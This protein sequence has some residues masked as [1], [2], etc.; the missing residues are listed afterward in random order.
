[1]RGLGRWKYALIILL[2]LHLVPIW[3]FKFLPTQD[4]LNHVYNAYILKEYNNP[5]YTK[6]REVYRLNIKPLPN[7]NAHAFLFVMLHIVPPLIAEKFYVSFCVLLAPFAFFYF[8]KQVDIRLTLFALLGFLYSYNYFINLGFYG[9]ALGFSVYFFALGYWWRYRNE[10][11]FTRAAVFNLLI[12]ATYFSHLFSYSMLLLSISLLALTSAVLPGDRPRLI[13]E[14]VKSFA[15]T[16]AALLPAYSV[17]LYILMSNPEDKKAQIRSFKRLWDFFLSVHSLVSFNDRAVP[18]VWCLLGLMGL[19]FLWKVVK[20]KIIERD[21]IGQRDGF[22]ILFCISAL[23]YFKLPWAYGSPG[24][25]NA[26]MNLFLF[27]ILLAWFSFTYPKWLQ[28]ALAAVLICLALAHLGM[29]T[30]DYYLL[31]K[32]MR[33]FTSGAHLIAPNSSISIIRSTSTDTEYHGPLKHATP[34]YHATCYYGLNNGGVYVG[35][36]EPKYVYFPLRYRA[37]YWKFEYKGIIDYMLVWRKNEQ[38]EEVLQLKNE[39]ELI[40]KTKNLMLFRFKGTANGR[41]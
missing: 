33:E 39:Y 27:P 8:L 31:D 7:L 36:Y 25:I 23:L 35:N 24:W 41:E 5:E 26:R 13:K 22:L 12:I 20:D 15:C 30:R 10:L 4:G 16:V 28:Y 21:F 37:G 19:C 9:F 11:N 14:R 1:M 32:D 34:F 17:L 38:D 29:I 2:L 18:L 3:I 6:F 40:H